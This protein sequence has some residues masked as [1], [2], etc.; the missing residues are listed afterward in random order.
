M[1]ILPTAT[2][3]G[4]T[5][6]TC[7]TNGIWTSVTCY[8]PEN[9]PNV[10]LHAHANPHVT[11]LLAGATLEK[12]QRNECYRRAG[13]V[14]FFHAGEPHQNTQTIPGSRNFNIEFAPDFFETYGV[15]EEH[16]SEAI[17]ND[18]FAALVFLRA[19]RHFLHHDLW[20]GDSIAMAVFSLLGTRI[21]I[22]NQPPR[23]V[24]QISELLADRWN[25]HVSLQELSLETGVHPV[26]ISKYFPRYFGG[27][28]SDYMRK[29]RVRNTLAMIK[30]TPHKLTH[31][32]YEAGF[33]D[34]SHFTKAFREV[35]GF[36]PKEYR[37]I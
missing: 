7:L 3:L 32:A 36:L 18:P 8:T 37:A 23:W 24:R 20:A 14:V 9:L 19:Y 12:R 33:A 4:N 21:K 28:L 34:Q 1:E 22:Y 25:E 13:E 17:H 6:A 30:N 15:G 29:L 16:I 10:S 26:T 27:T 5:S 2:Y 31:I 35:T 11:M